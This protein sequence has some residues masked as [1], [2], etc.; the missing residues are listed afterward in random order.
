MA[1]LAQDKPTKMVTELIETYV[2]T[3]NPNKKARKA[4]P[5]LTILEETDGAKC[6]SKRSTQFNNKNKT[7]IQGQR[8]QG[9]PSMVYKVYETDPN[10][11]SLD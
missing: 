8:G 7:Q 3:Q 11:W 5:F 4:N 6:K 2:D 10:D 1:L 9:Q